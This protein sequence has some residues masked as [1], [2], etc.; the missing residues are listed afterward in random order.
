[1]VLVAHVIHWSKDENVYVDHIHH[2]YEMS[3]YHGEYDFTYV[4]N[5]FLI[6]D[7]H[8]KLFIVANYNYK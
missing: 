1:M 8:Y 6:I 3:Q 7:V 5:R 2:P 4:A